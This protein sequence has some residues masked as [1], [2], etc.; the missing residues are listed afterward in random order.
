MM[1]KTVTN[2][3][4]SSR[5]GRPRLQNAHATNSK[6][7]RLTKRQ[8]RE[9]QEFYDSIPDGE[10]DLSDAPEAKPGA[11]GHFFNDRHKFL[12]KSGRKRSA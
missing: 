3:R 6:A 4:E 12:E 2:L 8:V 1:K 11:E 10:I 5:S 9:L 7:Q